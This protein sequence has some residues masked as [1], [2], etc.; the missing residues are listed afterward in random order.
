ML[1]GGG[2]L[3]GLLFALH[4]HCCIEGNW[5]MGVERSACRFGGVKTSSAVCMS[6]ACM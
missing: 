6:G 5:E 1:V 4:I 2:N 3:G